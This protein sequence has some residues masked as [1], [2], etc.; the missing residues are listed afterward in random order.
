[1]PDIQFTSLAY[2]PSEAE[3]KYGDRIHLIANPFL[4]SH[5]VKLCAHNTQQPTVNQLVTVLYKELLHCVV[6]A[7]FPR[8]RVKVATRMIKHTERAI[9]DGEVVDREAQAVTVNIARAGSLPS[10]VCF[11]SLN[12]VLEPSGVRQDHIS[13]AR[14][15]DENER[16]TG[17]V[18]GAS[19]IG[20]PV[21]GKFVLFPDPM[22]ATGSSMNAAVGTYKNSVDGEAKAYV[23]M[24]LIVTPEYLKRTLADHPDLHV[25]AL[26]LDRGLSD[27]AV[28]K[29]VP[30][31]FWDREQGL[32]E[33]GY[34]V[35]GAGGLGEVMNNSWV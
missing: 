23:G 35:P 27:D 26:R 13:M 16:I 6:N 12:V 32:D 8:T 28:L 31:T 30:G 11:D 15:T 4:Q 24:H 20:G 14:T 22:G 25:F 2:R 3:H 33:K 9:Y 19:K 17:A 18:I 21:D 29:T 34:I 1:M 7:L 5:L 10:Q